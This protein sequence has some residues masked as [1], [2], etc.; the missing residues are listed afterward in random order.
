MSYTLDCPTEF[1]ML[2]AKHQAAMNGY[3]YLALRAAN[4]WVVRYW[5]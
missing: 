2:E 3:Y 5:K 1:E 4:G